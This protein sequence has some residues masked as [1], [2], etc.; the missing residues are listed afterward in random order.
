[1]KFRIYY[2]TKPSE[3]AAVEVD[4]K[5]KQ[6]AINKRPPFVYLSSIYLVMQIRS[7][8]KKKPNQQSIE[9]K[10]VK[11]QKDVEKALTKKQVKKEKDLK[12]KEKHPDGKRN[13][14]NVQE[15]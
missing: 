2:T 8:E 6:D 10:K 9:D 13:K 1:M 15:N 3:S 12:W 7:T 14:K 11:R 4:A 5:S